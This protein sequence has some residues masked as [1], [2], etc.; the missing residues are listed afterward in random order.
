MILKEKNND[1]ALRSVSKIFD[2]IQAQTFRGNF[3]LIFS[4]SY[5]INTHVRLR[6]SNIYLIDAF[7]RL[8]ANVLSLFLLPPPSRFS[9]DYRSTHANNALELMKAGVLIWFDRVVH[10]KFLLFWSFNRKRFL[11]HIRYYGSTNFTKGGLITNI[12]EFYHNRRGWRFYNN[13]PRYHIFYLNTALERIDEI[14]RMYNSHD[15]WAK[16]LDDLQNKIP[17]IVDDLKK[18]VTSAKDLIEKLKVSIL[19]YSYILEILSNIWNLPGKQFA[20]NICE[21]L[22]PAIDDYSSFN[23]EFLEELIALPDNVL[24]EFINQWKIKVDKYFEIPNRV[25]RHIS[26]LK[27]DIQK[28]RKEGYEAYTYPE[29]KGLMR[30]LKSETTKKVFSILRELV[31]LER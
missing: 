20:Y 25:I 16:N 9:G 6:T 19:S 23:L 27:K 2:E 3:G 7:R 26:A 13:L 14:N 11:R 31:A 30:R 18:K 5:T 10:S 29:E 22:I 17:K 24:N 28:Y 8:P 1:I 12:E 4:S 15:Y 21:K